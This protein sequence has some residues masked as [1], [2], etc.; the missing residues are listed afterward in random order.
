VSS[1][2]RLGVGVKIRM[3]RRAKRIAK[4]TSSQRSALCDPFPFIPSRQG[5]GNLV[6][7]QP[8]W[9]DFRVHL[10][11]FLQQEQPRFRF[12]GQELTSIFLADGPSPLE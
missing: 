10:T 9:G 3:A 4:N 7:G 12:V 8:L 1:A 6:A 5:S 11:N 2:E